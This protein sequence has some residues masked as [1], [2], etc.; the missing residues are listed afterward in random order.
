MGSVV[1]SWRRLVSIEVGDGLLE[2]VS[3]LARAEDV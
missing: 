2:L 3:V 1:L